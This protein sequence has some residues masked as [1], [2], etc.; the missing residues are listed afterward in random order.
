MKEE[1]ESLLFL[2]LSITAVWGHIQ[3]PGGSIL[4]CTLCDF[5][6]LAS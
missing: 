4:K 6:V 1:K 2:S 3:C 5:C